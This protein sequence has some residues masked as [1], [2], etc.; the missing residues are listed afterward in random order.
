MTQLWSVNY[1][2][3]MILFSYSFCTGKHHNVKLMQNSSFFLF[4]FVM[5]FHWMI[6]FINQIKWIKCQ[7][8]S[9]SRLSAV[10]GCLLLLSNHQIIILSRH[11]GKNKIQA[12]KQKTKNSF[13]HLMQINNVKKRLRKTDREKK[14]VKFGKTKTDCLISKKY[15][16]RRKCFFYKKKQN[17]DDD[18]KIPSL[19]LFNDNDEVLATKIRL[20]NSFN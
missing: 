18:D 14:I 17:S 16:N 10:A 7:P 6:W 11:L 9:L 5:D 3:F 1:L 2:S 8:Y 12:R 20:K 13:I 15:D 19:F 4:C